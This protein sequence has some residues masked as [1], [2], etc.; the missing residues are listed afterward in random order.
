MIVYIIMIPK[1]I[2]Q[3]YYEE[4]FTTFDTFDEVWPWGPL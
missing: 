1:M 4:H 3:L 2:T